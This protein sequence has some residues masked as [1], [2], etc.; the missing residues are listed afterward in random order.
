MCF[1][2]NDKSISIIVAAIQITRVVLGGAKLIVP[3]SIYHE[4]ERSKYH[5]SIDFSLKLSR[6]CLIFFV[7]DKSFDLF[8]YA[9]CTF[10]ILCN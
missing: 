3:Q 4:T 9:P 1:I 6:L 10:N 8:I 2:Y 5:K 7:I